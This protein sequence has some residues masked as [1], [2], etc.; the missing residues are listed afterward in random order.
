MKMFG[1][2][3]N[4]FTLLGLS[5]A[6]GIGANLAMHPDGTEFPAEAS[7]SKLVTALTIADARQPMDEIIEITDED[8]ATFH[9]RTGLDATEIAGK[10]VLDA[11]CGMGRYLRIA[12]E[13]PA[14]L[15]VGVDLTLAVLATAALFGAQNPM[16]GGSPMYSSKNIVENA[17]NSKDHTTP[18]R[19]RLRPTSMWFE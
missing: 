12:A 15:V 11:G 7:I 10:V 13:S 9:G 5:L 18:A 14:R 2:T 16:V 8:R 6:I 4:F 17:S 1:F 3:I 19:L